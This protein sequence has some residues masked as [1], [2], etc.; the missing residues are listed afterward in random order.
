M[1]HPTRTNLLLLKEKT[2]SVNNSVGI[3]KARRQALIREFLA[4]SVPFLKSREDIRKSY[5]KAIGELKLSMGQ[6]GKGTIESLA[7]VTKKDLAVEMAERSI[8]GLRYRDVV[9]HESPVR[10]PDERNY[11]Y[12][13]TSPHLEESIF[14][15][16]KIVESMIEIATYESKLK[17][18]GE[19]IVKST[20]RIRVLE[21]RLLPEL[22]RQIKVISQYIGERERETYYR[23]KRFKN[24]RTI[25][26]EQAYESAAVK[27]NGV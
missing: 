20:R 12:R 19:E 9:M 5:G 11:D 23:L 13:S 26:Q 25:S 6:E 24:I 15:F 16:E 2:H 1:I 22:T 10:T 18:L 14:L 17:R 27:E 8:W 4:T 21:E 3:L 7:L